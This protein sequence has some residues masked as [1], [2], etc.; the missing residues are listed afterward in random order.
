MRIELSNRWAVA[1]MAVFANVAATTPAAAQDLGD[2]W[3]SLTAAEWSIVFPATGLDST[4]ERHQLRKSV[5]GNIEH[6]IAFWS[7]RTSV[8][9]KAVV[10]YMKTID[11]SA[12]RTTPD[13]RSIGEEG[14]FQ[15]K[16]VKFDSLKKD[17]NRLGRVQW[18]QFHFD[19]VNCVSFAQAWGVDIDQRLAGDHMIIGY[20][21]A[22]P[23]QSLPEEE[24]RK[25]VVATIDI[26]DKKDP[27]RQFLGKLKGPFDGFWT[28]TGR[29][30]SGHCKV[31]VY[32]FGRLESV[33][34]EL[35]IRE[36]EITGR[37]TKGHHSYNGG[38]IVNA[39]IRG[40]L[41]DNGEFDIQVGKT[42]LGAELVL[43]GRLPKDGN[44][45]NG[46]WDTPNCHGIL[47]LTRE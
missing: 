32:S 35:I 22:E 39:P 46:N 3:Q 33:R 42:D 4:I 45:G 23:G 44:R 20:Y 19:N 6:E 11:E 12:W 37:V 40:I 9:P 47:S 8:Y 31:G 27:K 28:G 30:E 29:R 34:F 15:E 18:R 26:D 24:A 36:L 43:R 21:C 13:P 17:R 16:A 25:I 41:G 2:E 10:H 38:F 14:V 1:M 7:G 5:N